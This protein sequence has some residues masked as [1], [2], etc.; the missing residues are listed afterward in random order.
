MSN[1]K[2][3][4]HD[5]HIA[6]LDRHAQKV[7]EQLQA[8]EWKILTTP[9]MEIFAMKELLQEQAELEKVLNWFSNLKTNARPPAII[10]PNG[11]ANGLKLVN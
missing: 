1:N 8:N 10:N 6:N 5:H 4:V 2:R 7:I 11:P 9:D 3:P